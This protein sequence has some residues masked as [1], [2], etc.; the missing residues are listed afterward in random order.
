MSGNSKAPIDIK[1]ESMSFDY[2]NHWALWTG[3]VRAVQDNATLTSDSLRVEYLDKDMKQMKDAIADG[4]VRMS[5]GTQWATGKHAI[6]DQRKRTVVL[7]GSPVAHDGEN[8][9]TGSRITVFMDTGKSLV[10]NAHAVIYSKKDDN[11]PGGAAR[12]TSD[13]ATDSS[14]NTTPSS[15]GGP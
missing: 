4:N 8:Q 11:A 13:D 15:P 7:T 3:R 1:S 6:M 9:I 2:N 10:E 14:D 12:T 5:Q